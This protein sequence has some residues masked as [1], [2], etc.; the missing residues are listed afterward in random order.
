MDAED[1]IAGDDKMVARVTLTGTHRGE[2]AGI[3]PTDKRV[4]V[5]LI[6]IMRFDDAGLICE[7]W[8]VADM[9]SLM[10]QLGVV[11]F[12][13]AWRS[14]RARTA[15]VAP[16]LLAL[17]LSVDPRSPCQGHVHQ[18]FKGEPDVHLCIDAG[19]DNWR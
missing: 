2:F 5:T 8:G 15:F 9:L 10:Q 13:P 4:E 3:P 19:T 16:G 18:Q 17:V 7:H 6:D 12:G 14:C 1:V 11:P